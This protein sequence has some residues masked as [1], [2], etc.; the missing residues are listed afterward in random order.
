[1]KRGTVVFALP[2]LA[3]V[4]DLVHHAYTCRIE[5]VASLCR[6]H[7]DEFGLNVTCN[8]VCDGPMPF[9]VHGETSV[10]LR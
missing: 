5:R 3:A 7:A 4:H 9:F 8:I 6:D 10:F 1:M 2:R